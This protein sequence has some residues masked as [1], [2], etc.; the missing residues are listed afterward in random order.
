MN[1]ERESKETS[2]IIFSIVGGLGS[3]AFGYLK[4]FPI[5]PFLVGFLGGWFLVPYVENR[6]P[7][8]KDHLFYFFFGFG[9]Y[10]IGWVISVV[11]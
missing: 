7:S 2:V 9:S 10:A 3:A 11:L 6:V 4:I 1:S 8:N 5:L